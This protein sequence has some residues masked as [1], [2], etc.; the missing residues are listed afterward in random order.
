MKLK[1]GVKI[2]KA[3]IQS[4]IISQFVELKDLLFE[5]KEQNELIIISIGEIDFTEFITK[6]K[7][8]LIV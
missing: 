3:P 7:D 6:I 5:A 1:T 2:F 8:N 4:L